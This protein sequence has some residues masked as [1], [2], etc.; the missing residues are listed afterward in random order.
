M[1]VVRRATKK[2]TLK[3]RECLRCDRK[4]LSEGSYNRLCEPCRVYLE[5]APTPA[6]VHSFEW[7][8]Q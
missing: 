7:R 6:E 3:K 8:G 5:E 1:R 4:F 2:S